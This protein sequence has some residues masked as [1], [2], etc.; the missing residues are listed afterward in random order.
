MKFAD[1]SPETIEK[2]K[3]YR[4]DRILEKHEGP[5]KWESELKW[6]E[7]EFMVADGYNVLLPLDPERRPNVTF[8]R[9][10]PS[11]DG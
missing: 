6:G 5:E 10:I 3:T 1:L 4:W 11:T 7:P 8:L 2:I 9:V